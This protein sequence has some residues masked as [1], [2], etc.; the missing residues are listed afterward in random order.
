LAGAWQ[1]LGRRFCHRNSGGAS[2]EKLE[3]FGDQVCGSAGGSA[4]P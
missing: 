2:V 1:I 4:Q 3:K